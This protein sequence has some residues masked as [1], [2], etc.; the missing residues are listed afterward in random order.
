MMVGRAVPGANGFD[1]DT[2]VSAST[3]RQL[4]S[5]GFRFA[6][7]YVGRYSPQSTGDLSVSEVSDILGAGLALMPVQ[8]VDRQGWSPTA[9]LGISYGSSAVQNV[10]SIAKLP[11]GVTVWL[12]LEEPL[13][14]TPPSQVIAFVNAWSGEVSNAGFAPG[15]YVGAGEILSASDLYWRLRVQRYWKSASRVPNVDVRGYCMIQTLAPSPVDGISIDRDVVLADMLGMTPS[16]V[17][18]G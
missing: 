4:F 6:I 11:E 1:T 7:R 15:L 13:V 10:R 12:D 14:T 17:I 16:W 9:A 3:A 2:I 18:P 5:S 8:H